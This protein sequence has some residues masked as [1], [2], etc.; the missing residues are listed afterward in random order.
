[1]QGNC[2]DEEYLDEHGECKE[3][4]ERLK[5]MIRKLCEIIQSEYPESDDRYEFAGNCLTDVGE[6]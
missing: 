1:M 6:E 2:F 5:V 4:I 3:E